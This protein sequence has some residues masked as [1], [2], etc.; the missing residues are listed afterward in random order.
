[1]IHGPNY[2]V[3][4]S[5]AGP[6]RILLACTCPVSPFGCGMQS[7]DGDVGVRNAAQNRLLE[8]S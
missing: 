6:V 2:D 3:I 5:G 4:V 1:M 7:A 8:I